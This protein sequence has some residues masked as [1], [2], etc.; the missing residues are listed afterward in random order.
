MNEEKLP[1]HDDGKFSSSEKQKVTR[2]QFLS[3]TIMG[4][5]GF[6]A[7]ATVMPM[8]R[9]AADPVL[10]AKEEGELINTKFPVSNITN[11]PQLS[12]L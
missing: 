4:V 11:E 12:Y 10:Q 3:Y 7:A 9:F 6:M 2:R 5:G 1:K 8:L